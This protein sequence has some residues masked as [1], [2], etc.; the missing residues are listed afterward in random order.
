MSWQE[1]EASSVINTAT[2]SE[3]VIIYWY[4]TPDRTVQV[5]CAG[6]HHQM[7]YNCSKLHLQGIMFSIV[8]TPDEKLSTHTGYT[9]QAY[10]SKHTHADTVYTHRFGSRVE[11]RKSL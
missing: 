6:F 5:P 3:K 10:T 1:Q 8:C 9:Q 11:S 4:Y 2:I 7:T